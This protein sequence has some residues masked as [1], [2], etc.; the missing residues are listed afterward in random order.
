MAEF[1]FPDEEGRDG[2]NKKVASDLEIEVIDDTPPEDRGKEP[3]PKEVLDKATADDDLEKYSAEVQNRIKT[4]KKAWHDE[5]R[6]K[7]SKVRERDEAIRIAELNLR[8]N[9]NLKQRLTT[10]EKI[11][12]T[13][14][15]QAAKAGLD[16]A[17]AK[18]KQAYESGD[19][20]LIT[21]A[22]EELQDAKFKLREVESF[23]PSLQDN[24]TQV[25]SNSQT[26]A[27]RQSQPAPDPKASVWRDKNKWFGVD[28]EMTAAA[29]GLHEKLVKQGVDPRSDEY[30]D[31][32]DKTM[33]RRFP[34]NFE[35]NTP[36]PEEK[37]RARPATV[38]AGASRST[39]P[40]QVRLTQ[41]QVALAKRLGITP[42]AYARELI[43]TENRDNG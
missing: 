35:E 26:Q 28:E 38:V 33:R 36:P 42:E 9:Q 29:L 21:Q 24:N 27:P 34:E 3:L 14:V 16:S 31:K 4:L 22:Q 17:R 19:A 32:V 6:E 20:G 15:T 23:K 12:V 30:Y 10:G 13:E 43:K 11:F 7:E 8:E 25:E 18:L 40:R 1:K 41:T 5:R 37:P 2:P 39:A